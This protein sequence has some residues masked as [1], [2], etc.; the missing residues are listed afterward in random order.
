MAWFFL[1]VKYLHSGMFDAAEKLRIMVCQANNA[2][3]ELVLVKLINQIHH[4][5]FQPAGM[6]RKYQMTNMHG[7]I[8]CRSKPL[9]THCA[10]PLWV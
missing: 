3:S 9:V 7:V 1:Q 4:T 8:F 6:K 2:V 10:C 5:V